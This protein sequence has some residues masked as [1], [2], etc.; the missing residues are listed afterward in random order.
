MSPTTLSVKCDRR[1]GEHDDAGEKYPLPTELIAH[2]AADENQS[3][4]EQ[5]VC[6]DHPDVDDRGMQVRL[7][8]GQSHNRDVMGAGSRSWSGILNPSV[9][10]Q[11]SVKT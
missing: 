2:R 9:G 3:A 5:G 11:Y 1:D 7:E 8:R 10:D 4:E 6:L